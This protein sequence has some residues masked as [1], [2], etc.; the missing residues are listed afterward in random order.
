MGV[1][2]G[3]SARGLWCVLFCAVSSACSNVRAAPVCIQEDTVIRSFAETESNVIFVTLDGVRFQE[4]YEGAD[5]ALSGGDKGAAFPRFWASIARQGQV[6]DARIANPIHLSLPGYQSVFAG[7]EQPCGGND[8]GQIRV[9]TFPERLVED[10]GLPRQSVASFASW[11]GIARAVESRPGATFVDVGQKCEIVGQDPWSGRPHAEQAP[12]AGESARPDELTMSRAL[13]HLERQR[14]AFLYISLNDA[15]EEAH[16][17]R[18]DLYM[19]TLRR[20]DRWIEAL[21]NQLGHMGEYGR[22]TALLITTDHGRGQGARWTD[23]GAKRVGDADARIWI[24]LRLPESGRFTFAA[25]AARYTHLDL[26]PTIE[27]L[28]GLM[29]RMGSGLGASL[30]VAAVR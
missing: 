9:Q 7:A 12:S 16:R 29:P 4:F 28:Y 27:T 13:R 20:Y 26:R 17:G 2:V 30:V 15:D 5:R 23:H 22:R 21:V 19:A 18:Y 3:A 14:P 8:C 24:Y 6:Y 11:T 1:W 10:L 25:P